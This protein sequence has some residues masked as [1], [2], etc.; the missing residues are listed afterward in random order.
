MTLDIV[1]MWLLSPHLPNKDKKKKKPSA[2]VCFYKRF[3]L[4]FF[5]KISSGYIQKKKFP[6]MMRF[7]YSKWQSVFV[8][9][10]EGLFVAFRV[11]L[12]AQ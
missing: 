2:S 1:D 4:F 5:C 11:C 9:T 12:S 6:Y 8:S 10:E 7:D 3:I